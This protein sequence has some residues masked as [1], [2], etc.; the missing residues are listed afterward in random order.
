MT[1]ITSDMNFKF[2]KNPVLIIGFYLQPINVHRSIWGD[3]GYQWGGKRLLKTGFI[4]TMTRSQRNK[5]K[6]KGSSMFLNKV[7]EQN[8][9]FHEILSMLKYK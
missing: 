2:L 4:Q 8:N 5:T 3:V 6:I 1:S 9:Y 7:P